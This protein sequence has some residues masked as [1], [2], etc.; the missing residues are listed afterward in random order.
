MPYTLTHIKKKPSWCLS[1]Y[2]ET[3]V[4]Y[5]LCPCS[6]LIKLCLPLNIDTAHTPF[7]FKEEK[8]FSG[9]FNPWP[10]WKDYKHKMS[11]LANF[12]PFG[13]AINTAAP[14]RLLSSSSHWP[15]AMGR[16]ATL[17]HSDLWLGLEFLSLP[18][19]SHPWIVHIIPVQELNC[20]HTC[21]PV[22][23]HSYID[24]IFSSLI[25]T[26]STP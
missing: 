15:L 5:K 6:C 3:S 23:S 2:A 7:S 20:F 26:N 22:L 24:L 1:L 4:L 25:Q 13:S 18:L 19:N 8:H 21:T 9:P 14:L 17:A 11:L 12:L 16:W 10:Y